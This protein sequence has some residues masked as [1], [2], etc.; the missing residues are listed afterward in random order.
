MISDRGR[1]AE[2]EEENRQL[3]DL[4]FA[5]GGVSFAHAGKTTFGLTATEALILRAI[6]HRKVITR[7]A[8]YTML[9]GDRVDDPPEIK[10]VDVFVSKIR[11][12]LKSRDIEIGTV[13]G[14]GWIIDQANR[15]RLIAELGCAPTAKGTS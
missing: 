13:W 7:E 15:D 4:L 11:R 5:E 8:L 10:I 1:I 9:Y 14:K 6:A 12:R 3:R 2:L